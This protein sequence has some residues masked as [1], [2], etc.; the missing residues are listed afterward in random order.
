MK[1]YGLIRS[2]LFLLEPEH[3]HCISL[4][5]MDWLNKF[6]LLRL[7]FGR[8]ISLPVSVMGITFPNPIGL[9]AGLDKNGD[10]INSLS[11][12][13]FG[14]NRNWHSDANSPNWK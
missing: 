5:A 1:L 12:C 4:V 14:F 7:F 11:S 10:H 8:Q 9:A 6:G 13:G 2:V 3:A